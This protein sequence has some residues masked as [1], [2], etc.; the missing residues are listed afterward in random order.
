MRA[1]VDGGAAGGDG[2][3]GVGGEVFDVGHGEEE[4]EGRLAWTRGAATNPATVRLTRAVGRVWSALFF[5]SLFSPAR[6]HHPR[7]VHPPTARSPG[8]HTHPR[9]ISVF[10]F[11]MPLLPPAVT[12]RRA[13]AKAKKGAAA[14][15]AAAAA[16]GA[17]ADADDVALAGATLASFVFGP[18]LG[19]REEGRG[20]LRGGWV[21]ERRGRSSKS[22]REGRPAVSL[23]SPPP[24]PPHTHTLQATAPLAASPWP[25]TPPPAAWPPSKRCRRLTWCAQA[26]R[27]TSSQRRPSWPPWVPP[28]RPSSACW[29]TSKM[30]R[31]CTWCWSMRRGVSSFA[32]CARAGGCPSP[33]PASTRPRWRSRWTLCMARALCT[34]I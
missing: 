25:V 3:R 26:K 17:A 32:T 29:P 22:A 7:C 8:P 4:E 34:V 10:L 16:A 2:W 5:L 24:P 11:V 12:A 20:G 31:L 23:S 13:A 33:P 6:P 1:R 28:P 9:F 30:T 21:G 19:E 18:V 14:A 15:A 27:P